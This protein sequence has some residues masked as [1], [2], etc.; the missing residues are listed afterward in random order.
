[1]IVSRGNPTTVVEPQFEEDDVRAMSPRRNSEEVDKL[2]EAAR[3]DL[4]EQ[5][6]VLQSSLQ[7]IVDRV[8]TVKTEHEKLEGGNKFL[9]SYV[10][11][12]SL[13]STR[14]LTILQIYRRAHANFEDN[15]VSTSQVEGQRPHGE[16]RFLTTNS[17]FPAFF[18]DV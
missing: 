9:Q 8:E 13:E 1:M 16:M 11:D 2:G 15:I 18:Q 10:A 17:I 14:V 7:A 6:R 5:A 3:R 12:R 4:M